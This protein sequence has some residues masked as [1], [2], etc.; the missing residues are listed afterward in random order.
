LPAFSHRTKFATKHAIL[1]QL[2]VA[3]TGVQGW[4]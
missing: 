1:N 4:M 3:V 2:S